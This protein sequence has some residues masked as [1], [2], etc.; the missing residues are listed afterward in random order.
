MKKEQTE[1]SKFLAK[2][3]SKNKSETS[4]VAALTIGDFI[5]DMVRVDQRYIDGVNFSTPSK[6]LSSVFKIG[7]H[8][9]DLAS[10]GEEHLQIMHDRNYTGYTHEFVTHQWMR[11]R[12]VE[13]ELPEKFNQ[14][15]WDAIYNGQKWQIK[16]GSVENVREARLKNPD[17]PVATDLETAEEYRNK[18]PEDAA[19][20]LGTTPKSITENIV[21][22]GQEATMEVY[23]DDEFFGTGASEFLTIA[24]IPSI[25][26]NIS[27]I[28]EDKTNLETGIQN[29]AIDTVGRGVGMTIGAKA[30]FAVAGP[31]GGI[32]GGIGGAFLS[33]EFIDE[34]KL[35]TFCEKENIKLKTALNEWIVAVKKIFEK[36]HKTFDKKMEKLKSTLGSE[37]YRKKIFKENKLSKELFE[38]L[39][40]RMKDEFEY[41]EQLMKRLTWREH[42]VNPKKFREFEPKIMEYLEESEDYALRAG[43]PHEFV[44]KETEKLVAAIDSYIKAAEKRGV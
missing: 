14:T 5:Y 33:K 43:I 27:Y 20:V 13:V 3:I 36:N 24:S 30:G 9:L 1:L 44:Q 18:F 8:N 15:G 35:K 10:K 11:S 17:I 38:Y 28:N 6:D 12:G 2:K 41:E 34:F 23:E 22:E 7:K 4:G 42:V 39:I 26:R 32:V 25:I 37:I 16:F 31:I 19:L 40:S 29:V 21:S